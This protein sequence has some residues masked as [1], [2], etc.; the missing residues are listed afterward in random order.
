MENSQYRMPD[1]MAG[2]RRLVINKVKQKSQDK[3]QCVADNGVDT[4]KL[5]FYLKVKTKKS[6][7]IFSFK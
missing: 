2:N 5:F 4:K 7:F 3:Y 6:K 1:R